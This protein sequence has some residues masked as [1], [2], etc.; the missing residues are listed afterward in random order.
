MSNTGKI[1]CIVASNGVS[2]LNFRGAFIR[3]LVSL[4]HRVVCVSIEPASELS[5]QL[6]ALGAEYRQVCGDRTG[7]GL[8]SGLKMIRGYRRLFRELR[9]DHC[10]LYMSK[11]IAFG[12]IAAIRCKLPHIHILVNGLENAYYRHGLKDALVRFV[13]SAFYKHVSKHADNVFFQNPDDRNYFL[14]HRLLPR[15][16]S[17]LVNG[18]GVDMQHFAKAELPKDPI[19]LMVARLLWSKGIREFLKAVRTV[20]LQ[21]PELKV[22]LVGG[23]DD[24][25]EALSQDELQSF[26]EEFDIE[27]CGYAEDVRPYLRRCSIFVLPSYHEGLP[28]SVLEA[29]AVGR[30]IISTDVP[31]CR[32]TVI[33]GENGFLVPAKDAAALAEKML[34]LVENPELRQ[35]MA[36]SSFQICLERFEVGKVNQSMLKKIFVEPQN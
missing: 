17:S 5:A 33:E 4:G 9:P 35:K 2:L 1:F 10:F 31:G 34:L 26:I 16:N 36:E 19:I 8:L 11:P 3:E 25:D 18:S 27:Y 20:K 29:M 28:R 7:I 32:E 12:G 22:L 13:M 6:A 23:L 30:P 14:E 15:D 24:N 21:H